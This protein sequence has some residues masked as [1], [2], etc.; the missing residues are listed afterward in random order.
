MKASG[1]GPPKD[2]LEVIE[3]GVRLEPEVRTDLDGTR[4]DSWLFG[5][6]LHGMSL[7]G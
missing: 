6:T 2:F 1:G 4:N 7:S 5:G 3:G